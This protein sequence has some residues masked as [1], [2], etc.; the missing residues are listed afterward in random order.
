M[1]SSCVMESNKTRSR[2]IAKNTLYM[3]FR[4]LLVAVVSFYTSRVVLNILGIDDYG[5]YNVV[6][7]VVVFLSFF[8]NALN[9]ATYRYLTY[10]IGRNDSNQLKKLFAMCFNVHCILSIIILVILEFAGLWFLNHKLN[11]PL[12][13]LYATNCV[14][15]FS[16]FTFCIEILRTPLESTI[17]AHEHMSF[18]AVTSIVEV[19]LKLGVVVLLLI[20]PLDK[21]ILYA[22]L[23]SG[24]AVVMFLWY[25]LYCRSHFHETRYEYYWSTSTFKELLSYSGWSVLV[26]AADVSVAQCINIFLNI[27]YGVVANASMGIANQVNALIGQFLN[28]FTASF[29]P[30]IIKSYATG[31]QQ[32]FMKLLFSTSKLSY[33]LMFIIAFPIMINID[34]ILQIWL[35][36]PPEMAGIFLQCI[37]FYSLFDSFSSPL[38]TAVH[39]TGNL[40]THQILISIIKIVNV[41]LG[42]LLLLKGMPAYSIL[43]LYALLNGLCAIVRIIYLRYLIGLDIKK[44]FGEVVLR[45]SIVTLC[46]IIIPLTTIYI[47]E[48]EGLP[49]LILTTIVFMTIYVPCVYFVGLNSTEKLLVRQMLCVL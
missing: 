32:Y 38:W 48:F 10:G 43:I 39:A 21:L 36:K 42:Y 24:V 1:K 20:I 16:L 37:V 15:Q 47:I 34:Y 12:E 18:Y 29:K 26:N 7:S 3:F 5:I 30:Q 13:R 27:F 41:P 25:T 2:L 33:F 23:L 35:V 45:M 6:G 9:N 49:R 19:F 14:F 40:K 44:Y 8:K 46:S 11:I 28:S 22:C 17:I 4:M 31:E